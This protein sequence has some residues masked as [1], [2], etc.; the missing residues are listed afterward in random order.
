ME[1][2]TTLFCLFL[3]VVLSMLFPIFP[4]LSL[5]LNLGLYSFPLLLSLFVFSAFHPLS[6]LPLALL[7]PPL[8]S[9]TWLYIL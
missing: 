6:S 2:M 7:P 4:S 5:C 3:L 1:T 9:L 8:L